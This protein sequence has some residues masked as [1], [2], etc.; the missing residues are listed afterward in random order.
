MVLDSSPVSPVAWRNGR[1]TTRELAAAT[2][3]AEQVRRRISVADLDGPATFSDFVGMD[4]VIVPL[5]P[6]RLTIDGST[7]H[8]RRGEPAWFPGDAKVSAVP[9]QATRALNVMTRRRALH[10]EVVLRPAGQQTIGDACMVVHLGDPAADVLLR[11]ARV[12]HE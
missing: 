4:R 1:G 9:D 5:G 10:A 7:L 8:L 6:V 3:A 11:E 2:D 12:T